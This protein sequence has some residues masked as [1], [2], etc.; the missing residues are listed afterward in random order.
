[1]IASR[2]QDVTFIF[3]QHRFIHL[4][5]DVHTLYTWTNTYED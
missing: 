5:I 4:S 1:M 2:V 3:P